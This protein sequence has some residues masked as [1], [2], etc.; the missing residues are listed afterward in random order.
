LS[1]LASSLVCEGIIFIV[2][3]TNIG[4]FSPNLLL[5]DLFLTSFDIFRPV[6][7]VSKKN[8]N[9]KKRVRFHGVLYKL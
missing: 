7:A 4:L 9:L 3:L 8:G 5:L 2:H 6:N 1:Y